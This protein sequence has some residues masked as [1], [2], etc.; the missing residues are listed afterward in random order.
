ML[1]FTNIVRGR[2]GGNYEFLTGCQV[3]EK[4]DIGIV[5]SGPPAATV[6]RITEKFLSEGK[7]FAALPD[8]R[9]TEDCGGGA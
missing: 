8:K 2:R 3:E 6:K 4:T 1:K 7:E 9:R 5:K